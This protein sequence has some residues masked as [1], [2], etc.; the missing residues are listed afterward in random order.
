MDQGSKTPLSV[1]LTL[2]P[3]ARNVLRHLE[4]YGYITPAIAQNTYAIW[5]LAASIHEIRRKGINVETIVR[6][7]AAGHRYAY[8]QLANRKAA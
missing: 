7:D 1:A 2:K 6:Q 3:Q 5:R 4:R 8:Y